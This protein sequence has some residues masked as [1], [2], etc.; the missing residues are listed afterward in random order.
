MAEITRVHVITTTEGTISEESTVT[1]TK[2]AIGKTSKLASTVTAT[3][4]TTETT[5]TTARRELIIM[6]SSVST[7]RLVSPS[8]RVKSHPPS[9]AVNQ[10]KMSRK[11]R[12]FRYKKTTNITL[13]SSNLDP[14]Q[15]VIVK[16]I[17]RNAKIVLRSNLLKTMIKIKKKNPRRSL[18]G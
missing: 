15:L 5:E 4:E 11:M 18:T 14:N 3:E 2:E 1:E 17:T 16:S 13:I 8:A 10:R 12:P 7:K 6:T 9:Q